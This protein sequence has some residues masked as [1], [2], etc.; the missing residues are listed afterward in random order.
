M[1]LASTMPAGQVCPPQPE[2]RSSCSRR[3]SARSP[4]KSVAVVP[5][6]LYAGSGERS[7]PIARG[8]NSGEGERWGGDILGNCRC[9]RFSV[10]EVIMT[11]KFR[12]TEVWSR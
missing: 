6:A 2:A 1:C 8:E 7:S 12:L 3:G 4:A 10:R 9:H 5:A 11:V